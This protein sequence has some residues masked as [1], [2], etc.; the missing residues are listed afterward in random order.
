MEIGE[1]IL[2]SLDRE[3]IFLFPLMPTG[4]PE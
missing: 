3:K 1:E 4:E 2:W